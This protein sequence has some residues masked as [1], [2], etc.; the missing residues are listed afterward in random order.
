MFHDI[1]NRLG[2]NIA[3][4]FLVLTHMHSDHFMGVGHMLDRFEKRITVLGDC[5]VDI[6]YIVAREFP[7]DAPF[8]SSA[9]SDLMK[10]HDFKRRNKSKI[11]ALSGPN[12]MIYEDTSN[13]VRVRTIAPPASMLSDI[14]RHLRTLFQR[15]RSREA[16]PINSDTH[17]YDL[18][19]TS[20]AI[21]IMHE[22]CRIVV[23]GDVLQ[24]AW[25]AIHGQFPEL[26]S[27][28]FVLSHHGAGNGFPSR[29][30]SKWISKPITHAIVS[31][32][33]YNQPS[34]R[35]VHAVKAS[36]GKVWTTTLPGAAQRVTSLSDYALRFHHQWPSAT[37]RRS[38]VQCTW[39]GS[40][41]QINGLE[42]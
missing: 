15:L 33:G 22:G 40:E 5:G 28:V 7:S 23:G 6:P 16:M 14:T 21:E 30:W 11:K 38:D 25:N 12:V 4:E 18:N 19:R 29:H 3:V 34:D 2:S 35:V 32:E 41:I 17:Q 13:D 31:G 10:L 9:R 37:T 39:T 42:Y 24:P 36:G 1:Q 8:D 26:R 20:S 27:D